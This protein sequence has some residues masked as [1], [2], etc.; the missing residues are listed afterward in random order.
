ML[1][2]Y[3]EEPFAPM[4]LVGWAVGVGLVAAVL[5]RP[6][7]FGAGAMRPASVLFA[8]W[9]GAFFGAVAA[10]DAWA[11]QMEGRD[12]RRFAVRHRRAARIAFGVVG[13]CAV[14]VA[15]AGVVALGWSGELAGAAGAVVAKAVCACVMGTGTALLL[16]GRALTGDRIRSVGG[17]AVLMGLYLW[18]AFFLVF[19]HRGFGPLGEIIPALLTFWVI[20]RTPTASPPLRGVF[21]GSQVLVEMSVGFNRDSD[22]DM[23]R[24]ATQAVIAVAMGT[25]T[26][27]CVIR[28]AQWHGRLLRFGTAAAIVPLAYVVFLGFDGQLL[29]GP[30]EFPLFVPMAWIAVRLWRRMHASDRTL[31]SAA[32]DIV[33]AVLLG[34][35][36]VLFLVWLANLLHLPAVEVEVLRRAAAHLGDLIDL[37]WWQWASAD[38][39]LVAIFLTAAL[40]RRRLSRVTAGLSR[41]RL[42]AALDTLRLTLS[43]MKTVLLSLVFLGLAGPPAVGPVLSHAVRDHYTADLQQDLEAR[44]ETAV[45]QEISQQFTGSPKTLPVLAQLLVQVHDS[46]DASERDR[47]GTAAGDLAYRMGELQAQTLLPL[48]LREEDP[49]QQAAGP[50]TAAAVREAGM[51]GT[52]AGADDLADRLTREQN[53]EADA[54]ERERAAEQAAEHAATVVTAALGNLTFGHGIV[55]GLVREYLDGL[56]ESGLSTVFLRWT[57]RDLPGPAPEQPPA[58][59]EVV[60]PEPHALQAAADDQLSDELSTQSVITDPEQDRADREAPIAAAVDLAARTR[61]LQQGTAHVYVPGGDDPVREREPGIRE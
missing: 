40:G 48:A 47:P 4:W 21:L 36:L 11:L 35:L 18:V 22:G 56:A 59:A 19:E 54:H 28:F 10:G 50:P 20:I 30:L 25:V 60:E 2:G 32:A 41:M 3:F 46:A 53:E 51:D 29:G 49:A 52:A 38:A 14:L 55:I 26:V 57:D 16:V 42:S 45:Y 23:I 43:V 12:V 17:I 7:A 34:V 31:V 8:M 1:A 37:P 9:M 13:A 5:R 44:G 24:L 58:A 33:F 27:V 6:S 15:V 39:L 61:G